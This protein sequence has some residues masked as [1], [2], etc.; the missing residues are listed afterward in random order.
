M[1]IDTGH[2]QLRRGGRWL[3]LHLL[4]SENESLLVQV[5]CKHDLHLVSGSRRGHA[6]IPPL[7]SARSGCGGG[8]GTW[9]GASPDGPMKRNSAAS[10]DGAMRET[11]C[12]PAQQI[13][14]Q[15]IASAKLMLGQGGRKK[16]PGRG[17][18]GHPPPQKK[19]RGQMLGLDSCSSPIQHCRKDRRTT[20]KQEGKALQNRTSCRGGFKKIKQQL[21]FCGGGRR[22]TLPAEQKS[23]EGHHAQTTHPTHSHSNPVPCSTYA[24]HATHRLLHSVSSWGIPLER[25]RLPAC[26]L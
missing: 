23:W 5:T 17:G 21:S 26:H 10:Q 8:G 12:Y 14:T 15:N 1:F 16:K 11:G 9:V 25:D 3:L 4:S 2:F 7:I 19:E 20:K 22:K 24:G 18:E 6:E 13:Q